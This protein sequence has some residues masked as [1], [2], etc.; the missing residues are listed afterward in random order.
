MR[1]GHVRASRVHH[2]EKQGVLVAKLIE[3]HAVK[4]KQKEDVEAMSHNGQATIVI[5]PLSSE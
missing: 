5:N 2:L 4:R 1:S 3:A